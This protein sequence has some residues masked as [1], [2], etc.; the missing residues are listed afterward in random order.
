VRVVA[1]IIL[2]LAS[3]GCARRKPLR[4]HLTISNE[5]CNP[6]YL[7]SVGREKLDKC[8]VRSHDLI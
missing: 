1:L 5:T 8:Y 6:R 3:S 7:R 2:A 4:M